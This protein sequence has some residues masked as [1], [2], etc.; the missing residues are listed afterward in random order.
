MKKFSAIMSK[1]KREKD[2]LP[3]IN[4]VSLFWRVVITPKIKPGENLTG[5]TFSRRKFADVRCKIV[6]VS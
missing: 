5:D 2:F 6:T 4:R 3:Q 1:V